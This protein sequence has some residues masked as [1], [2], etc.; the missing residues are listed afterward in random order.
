MN[1]A[2]PLTDR[3][4]KRIATYDLVRV[5]AIT[6][7]IL[8][9]AREIA[10]PYENNELF[11]IIGYSIDRNG[12]P[13]FFFLTG[14]L[15]LT[16]AH[17]ISIL[18]FYRK[19]IPQYLLCLF[20]YSLLTN[21]IYQFT[22]GN[23]SLTD[24]I[25]I[26]WHTNGF[27][28]ANI[29]VAH[30]LWFMYLIIGVYLIIPFLSRL[31]NQLTKTQIFIFIALAV[32]TGAF[33]S[34]FP[35]AITSFVER[36]EKNLLGEVL[37]YF[38]FGYLI[39]R[40]NIRLKTK[41]EISFVIAALISAFVLF[42]SFEIVYGYKPE[43]HW[44][45]TSVP[46]MIT[47]SCLFVL[48]NSLPI[49]FLPKIFENISRLSFGMFLVHFIFIYLAKYFWFVIL[50][51]GNHPVRGAFFMFCFS[52]LCSYTIVKLASKIPIIKSLAV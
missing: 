28:G 23:K 44:Y 40:F 48:I 5:I 2:L 35:S 47:S 4:K 49:Q 24:A 51:L 6:L 3:T 30:Q 33:Q 41:R 15:V 34:S 7:V 42:D 43:W 37:P 11:N 27:I 16:K 10:G 1:S 39:Q 13:L 45:H 29:G 31:L 50:N 46:I 52:F 22:L 21:T 19:R 25:L 20:V 26:G 8:T 17:T 9:H 12:V 32:F 14:A 18:S 36:L 38:V